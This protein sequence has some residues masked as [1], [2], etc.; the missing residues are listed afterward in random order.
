MTRRSMLPAF[1]LTAVASIALLPAQ[2]EAIGSDFHNVRGVDFIPTYR[3]IASLLQI[4]NPPYVFHDVASPA[5]AWRAY[6][7]NHNSQEWIDIRDQLRRIHDVGLNTVRVWLS[8]HY[9]SFQPT[10]MVNKFLD[11]LQ[12]CQNENLHVIP[13][14]W[15]NDFHEPDTD[16]LPGGLN[17]GYLPYHNYANWIRSPGQQF[18]QDRGGHLI[19]D[20]PETDF[21]V[22]VVSAAH[23]FTTG[24]AFR[25][26]ILWDVMN[27]PVFSLGSDQQY[28]WITETLSIVKSVDP[29]AKTAVTP[30]VWQYAD[31]RHRSLAR[32]PNLDVLAFNFYGNGPRDIE[33]KCDNALH[34]LSHPTP[35]A[36]PIVVME[37]GLVGWGQTYPE[38]INLAENVPAAC[39]GT[40]GV[41]G[42][43]FCLFSANVGKY[44]EPDINASGQRVNVNFIAWQWGDGLFYGPEFDLPSSTHLKKIFVRDY[45]PG[46]STS[47]QPTIA[48]LARLYQSQTGSV[49]V[50]Q[51]E[52]ASMPATNI[53]YQQ[54]Y[55]LPDGTNRDACTT[56]IANAANLAPS[57]GLS[58]PSG[59]VV[60]RELIAALNMATWSASADLT[61]HL[62]E[63]NGYL[64][65]SFD[66]TAAALDSMGNDYATLSFHIHNGTPN[67]WISQASTYQALYSAVNSFWTVGGYNTWY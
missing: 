15:D 9:Y 29:G 18:I 13:I 50:H 20:G 36:K 55:Y 46:G 11:F 48:E 26:L 21:I 28:T 54:P 61:Y 3:N 8:F 65:G 66:D 64:F 44:L 35:I 33:G 40:T 58:N 47:V 12:L 67:W 10:D 22:S 49:L 17:G 52:Y 32:N 6:N 63:Q 19:D 2:M 14:L 45:G 43:G 51:Y 23:P 37:A 60:G 59:A 7:L 53:G 57:C 41:D 39:A 24:G 27:E 42:V 16:S 62:S 25:T 31:P 56:L 4:T 1:T 30:P 38:A 5:A 34:L